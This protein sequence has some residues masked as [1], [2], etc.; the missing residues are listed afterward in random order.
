MNGTLEP[1][2]EALKRAEQ[3]VRDAEREYRQFQQHFLE[4]ER[5]FKRTGIRPEYFEDARQ[6]MMDAWQ[7]VEIANNELIRAR[8]TVPAKPEEAR[9]PVPPA[10][11][12]AEKPQTKEEP[13]EPTERM[14]FVR[15]LVRSG[16]LNEEADESAIASPAIGPAIANAP[17]P[18]LSLADKRLH[19]S[20]WLV[21]HGR[22]SEA[23]KPASST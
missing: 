3:R 23:E 9:V 16:R 17:E 19:F 6:T 15:W 10:G 20:R 21:E 13:F 14:R 2:D 4:M 5:Q 7:D 8:R 18:V 11:A 1:G 12:I 22:I